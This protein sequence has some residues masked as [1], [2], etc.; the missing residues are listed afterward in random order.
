M[1][2]FIINQIIG[3]FHYKK[4]YILSTVDIGFK[5]MVNWLTG[6]GINFS[7][8]KKIPCIIGRTETKLTLTELTFSLLK[9]TYIEYVL[10]IHF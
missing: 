9:L 2:H 3:Q 1:L 8:K 5:Y 6:S 10:F 4:I 7:K